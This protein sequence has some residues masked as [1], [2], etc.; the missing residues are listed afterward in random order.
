MSRVVV[1]TGN[2]GKVRE[3]AAA[4]A[5]AGLEPFGLDA[6][7]ERPEVEETGQ[8]FEEN[9]ILKAEA[10]SRHTDL[11]VLAD[12]S[13]LEVDALG[14]DPGV[15]SA[16]YGSPDLD[17]AG[18][19]AR[20]LQE[21]EGTPETERT[22]RFRCVLAVARRGAILGVFEGSAEGRILES[23][24]GEN[25][26]GYD[27]VFFH[28]GVGATFA[29]IDRAKKQQLSH[30]GAAIRAFLDAIRSGELQL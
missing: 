28:E 20:V 24:R 11:P 3:F 25:G 26:F 4:L 19:C 17:D 14:G 10:Y 18:R 8:T 6:L 13:G 7:D 16:R 9:A 15:L 30:R 21:L 27:P 2:P 12:D 23:P 29:E 1:A 22:A 5:E